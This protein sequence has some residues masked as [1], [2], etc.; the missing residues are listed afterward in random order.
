M[1]E[2]KL[3]ASFEAQHSLHWA[4]HSHMCVSSH[5]HTHT[6]TLLSFLVIGLK[7]SLPFA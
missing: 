5:I 1:Q 6:H 2:K 4:P 3:T 7:Q